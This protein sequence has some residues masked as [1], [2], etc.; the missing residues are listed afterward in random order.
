M[1]RNTCWIPAKPRDSDTGDNDA[2]YGR[3]SNNRHQ[4]YHCTYIIRSYYRYR[5]M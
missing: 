1:F 4:D 2:D 5:Q 3:H